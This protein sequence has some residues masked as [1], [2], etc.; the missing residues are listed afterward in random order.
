MSDHPQSEWKQEVANDDKA[1]QGISHAMQ[2]IGLP[3]VVVTER[4]RIEAAIIE[5]SVLLEHGRL[6]LAKETLRAALK[7]E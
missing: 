4:D 1:I 3:S 7:D 6:D 5:A 2:S